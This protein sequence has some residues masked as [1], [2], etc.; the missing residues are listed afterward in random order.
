VDHIK[1]RGRDFFEKVCELDLEGI[2]AKG[3]STAYRGQREALP[4]LGQEFAV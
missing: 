4:L 2:V 1:A 3:K